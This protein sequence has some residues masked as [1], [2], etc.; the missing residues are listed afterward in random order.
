MFNK[1][2][3]TF[4]RPGGYKVLVVDLYWNGPVRLAA[5][6]PA[7]PQ[8]L[9][10]V[11]PYP[12]LETRWIAGEREWGWIVKSV[13]QVP[14]VGPAIEIA[15]RYAPASGPMVPPDPMPGT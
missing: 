2:H 3:V 14:D 4:R 10:L 11:N 1:G 9:N 15:R 13:D 5:A 6:V 8:Q 12:A 7:D